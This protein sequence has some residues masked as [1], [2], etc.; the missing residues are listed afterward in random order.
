MDSYNKQHRYQNEL[1]KGKR[2]WDFERKAE[3]ER[4][5]PLNNH[6]GTEECRSQNRIRKRMYDDKQLR[7]NK[8]LMR[9]EEGNNKEAA[10]TNLS[11]TQ[12]INIHRENKCVYTKKTHIR[13]IYT[14]KQHGPNLSPKVAKTNIFT[15]SG[16]KSAWQQGPMSHLY[17]TV[18]MSLSSWKPVSHPEQLQG[19]NKTA[20][21]SPT[22]KSQARKTFG[23][24]RGRI[25]LTAP[26]NKTDQ[27]TCMSAIELKNSRNI[28]HCNAEQK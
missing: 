23:D 7:Q 2:S 17:T 11:P 8:Y 27:N 12:R 14:L 4:V 18:T 5:K 25:P 10:D 6:I 3:D 24:K 16:K 13:D 26:K 15:R 20:Q 1:H 22:R 9:R 21:A 28:T 19:S